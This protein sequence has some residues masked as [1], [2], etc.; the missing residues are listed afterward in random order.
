MANY[1]HNKVEKNWQKKWNKAKINEVDLDKSKNPFFNLMMF[2]YPSA[3]G[4][5]IG[6]VYTFSGVD[7]FGRY[8]KMQ[9]H[10][11]FEPIGLDGFGIHSE[12]YAIKIGEH[13][14]D[15][16][17]RTEKHFYEQMKMTGNMYDWSRTVETYKPNY[18]KWTQ[19]LFVQLYKM[20][21]ATRKKAKVNWCPG[22]KTVLSDEQVE[23]GKCERCKTEVTKKS[24]E[25][26]FFKITDYAERL[27]NNLEWMDWDS[28]VKIGQKNWIGKSNGAIIKF[29]IRNSKYQMTELKAQGLK[30]M[31]KLDSFPADKALSS[32]LITHDYIEVFTTRPDTLFGATF[33]VVAPEH[34][35]I[36][37]EKLKI[38]N[39]NEV[40]KYVKA[41]LRKSDIDR[42]DLN[43]DKTGVRIDGLVA[44]NPANG[45]EIPVFV[46]D[47]VLITYGTGA[48][49][50]VPAHDERDFEFALKYDLPI[51]QVIKNDEKY[52]GFVKAV[53]SKDFQKFVQNLE[54]INAEFIEKNHEKILYI[55]SKKYLD[56]YIEFA[57]SSVMEDSWHDI[58][59]NEF[60][61]V[62]ADGTVYKVNKFDKGEKAFSKIK[63]LEQSVRDLPSLWHMLYNSH[64]KEFVCNTGDGE[65][66]N[67]EFLDGMSVDYATRKIISWLEEKN[68]GRK[69]TI[70]KLRDWCVSRQRYWGPPIPMI[71]I[72]KKL[73]QKV[74][75]I[76][77][78]FGNG[79]NNWFP[80][81]RGELE[82]EGIKVA[83]PTIP[84]CDKFD[85]DARMKF[86]EEEYKDFLDENSILIGH[87]SGAKTC[88]D[89]AEKHK[90]S[91]VIL[92]A[93]Y[94]FAN[95]NAK[96]F[97]VKDFGQDVCDDLFAY[98]NSAT[99]FQ[100]VRKNVDV[101]Y[102]LFGS[103]D[104][105]VGKNYQEYVAKYLPSAI[106]REYD[107]YSHFSVFT[108]DPIEIKEL[109]D[110]VKIVISGWRPVKE[111]DLPV[112]LPEIDKFEDILP[113]GSGKGP[114][115]KVEKFAHI[116]KH[117][118]RE[119]D[120]SDP[121]VDS[122]WYFLR[123]PFTEFEDKPFE[124]VKR[125]RLGEETKQD[126]NLIHEFKFI[127]D[128]FEQAHLFPLV[129]GSIAL[130]GINGK[131]FKK[132]K[133]IDFVFRSKDLTDKAKKFL[134]ERKYTLLENDSSK[135]IMQKG[136]VSV[137]LIY[138]G[139][140]TCED[141][142][143]GYKINVFGK[144][145]RIVDP[146]LLY[147][148]IISNSYKKKNESDTKIKIQILEYWLNQR[149]NK[150]L[151][152]NYYIGGKEHTVLHLLYARFITM[153]LNDFG[154]IDFEEPFIKFYGHGL[155]TKDGA[156]MSKSKGNIVNPDEYFEKFGADAVRLYLRFLGPFDKGGD[157]RDT[158][159]NGMK[160]FVNKLWRM[161][162]KFALHAIDFGKG[163]NVNMSKLHQTIK[164]VGED[165]QKLRFNTVV[166]KIMELVNWYEKN[167]KLFNKDQNIEIL[168]NLALIL[169]PMT[170][171]IA[172]SFWE[173][174]NKEIDPNWK[175]SADK[176]VHEQ[177]WPK[178]DK[179]LLIEEVITLAVQV[180][181][182]V[183]GII[184]INK[185]FSEKE[186]TNMIVENEKFAK[187]NLNR[188][189]KVIFVPGRI[190]NFITL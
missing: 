160:K 10:D 105:W 173:I 145:V 146:K 103:K 23:D 46:A 56:K 47:Y 155:I 166:A 57:K 58:V 188:A 148:L 185:N 2:P 171:H 16:S 40:Q 131:T 109:L 59:G 18:Y 113:D 80:W 96:E 13:I 112:L 167:I 110:I 170:P 99:N 181:G 20:G 182:K 147:K 51:V 141:M 154:Y 67:S 87:S 72:E 120:V 77:G 14:R 36:E 159:M 78:T 8:M 122:C 137:N 62:L 178:Y 174:I 107:N 153:V 156:K 37:K 38:Q 43:K 61:M 101:L 119:T 132:I 150:W 74:L 136:N 115:E 5:H 33:L 45:K 79:E 179:T 134:E 128:L 65:M 139:Y 104:P 76:H 70:Y 142:Y 54:T 157:W 108:K 93:P 9:G 143:L 21:L 64:Y 15:V 7:T 53:W 55:I 29:E 48:I 152:V 85:Y 25:Q 24:M 68:Y 28:D 52:I 97:L 140:E 135:Y 17:K 91:G 4:L 44:I 83:S 118:H 116:D 129:T 165:L 95:A 84:D 144:K 90:L 184:Q 114:L 172:E 50:G 35:I 6:S 177:A 158:G 123:Y 162:S 81:L 12:N 168:K 149:I 121:F 88:L 187:Y 26:W 69:E 34:K 111:K 19:W 106:I 183:R 124:F 30:F 66:I 1:N 39:Y 164:G 63:E 94:I 71:Y 41:A 169:A 125:P 86:F 163:N 11:V 75:L 130:V 89:L 102:A 186:V 180:N 175:W 27:L 117:I 31:P 42:T 133:D 138:K 32:R 60:I 22:C 98:V 161:Y 82:K 100:K 151:P 126:E 49:M 176:S 73:N 190:I 3:E 92:V 127:Y 189:K